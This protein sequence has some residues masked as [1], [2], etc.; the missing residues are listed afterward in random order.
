M[1]LEVS[2]AIAWFRS[3][4]LTLLKISAIVETG[5]LH[6][7]SFHLEKQIKSIHLLFTFTENEFALWC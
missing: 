7:C 4:L 6:Q 2:L 5:L 1:T 3:T